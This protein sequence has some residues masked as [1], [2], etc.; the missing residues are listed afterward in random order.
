ME[1]CEFK[2][3]RDSEGIEF[4]NCLSSADV[5]DHYFEDCSFFNCV[6]SDISLERSRFSDCR[7]IDCDLSLARVED[8]VF[9]GVRFQGCRLLGIDWRSCNKNLFSG[10]FENSLLDSC[11]FD[12]MKLRR[13]SFLKCSLRSAL[14]EACD[15]REASFLG[16][17]LLHCSFSDADLRK[18]DFRETQGLSLDLL[19]GK[20][21][22]MKL[23]VSGAVAL[24]RHSGIIVEGLDG[25]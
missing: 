23:D 25:S 6:L 8:S 1:K 12:G 3:D 13:G 17:H 10:R 20:F 2:P 24:V 9:N 15:L 14:F 19:R 4:R 7:F 5:V 18:C 21:K 22:G 16:S 11:L